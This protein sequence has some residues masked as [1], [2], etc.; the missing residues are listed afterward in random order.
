M[1]KRKVVAIIPARMD[2]SRFPGK[3]L[4]KI[5]DLPMIEHVRRRVCLCDI[6]DDVYVATCDDE[7]KEKVEQFGGKV[8]MTANTHQRC[9]DRIEEAARKIEVDIVI[10]VQGDEPLFDPAALDILVKPMLRDNSILCTNLLSAINNEND[11]GDVNIVKAVL[12][13]ENYV[14]YYSRAPIPYFRVKNNS[15]M[16]RQTGL[17]AFDKSFLQQFSNLPPTPKEIAESVDFLRILEHRYR[18]LGVIYPQK[19][20]G[21]DCKDDILKVEEIFKKDL[22]QRKIYQRI[23]SL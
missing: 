6:I 2:S 18:I 1:D 14:M 19:T 7:I 12:D 21:V 8:I 5:I 10:I 20:V 23:L 15:P 11:L 4:A 9:T 17:S 16:Y 22:V 3:P 13:K